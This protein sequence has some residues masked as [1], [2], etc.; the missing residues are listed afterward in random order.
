VSKL[1]I[2][3]GHVLD[4][5]RELPDNSIQ[6]CVTSPPYWGL[7]SYLPSAHPLKPF[8]IG[9]ER[10]P[11]EYVTKMVAVFE[12]IRRVLRPDGT[13]WIN[14]GDCYATGA[15]KVGNSPGGGS[16]GERFKESKG[17]RGGRNGS[18][19]IA[20]YREDLTQP[21]RMPIPGLKPKDLCGMPWRVAFALQEA[22][23]YLRSD[24]IWDKPN[25]MPE[26]VTDRP[27][28]SHE[29]IFLLT[30]SPHYFYDPEQIREQVTGQAHDRGTGVNPKAKT[31]GKNSRMTVD[32]D[33]QHMGKNK[34]NE[35]FSAAVRGALF[36]NRNKRTVWKVA[37]Y[38]YGDAHFATYP[39]ELIRPC[40]LA[41]TSTNGAC[42]DCGSPYERIIEM[43]EPLI[44][45]Q[46]ACGGDM[47][48]E[49]EPGEGKDTNG[50]GAQ[51]PRDLKA[52]ILAGMRER[53]T[54]GWKKT[55]ECKTDQ[56]KPCVVLD[57][58]GGSGTTGHVALE[59]GREAILIELN[60]EYIP[61][62]EQRTNITPG[63]MI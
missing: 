19:G 59:E 15:V 27:T 54:V 29:Y 50:T 7:R 44:E 23:W 14:L 6:C 22:G 52:R 55:C 58:F 28:K 49:Y 26:S 36:Q 17:Y 63:L 45:Q 18:M 62:I 8:E 9:S 16:Q 13:C 46:R 37:T 30:K 51:N 34:Q 57:P 31:S 48:G 38:S 24:I 25:P 53:K 4:R 35:S 11:Q 3:Q 10:T 43:G 42:M 20:G 47:F 56:K 32:R 60:P 33:V 41:G 5:L 1:T 12:E 40:I 21:N 39:P 2:L 61:L